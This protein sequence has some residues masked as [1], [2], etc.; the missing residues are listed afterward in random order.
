[1]TEEAIEVTTSISID[2]VREMLI[3]GFES[4][5]YSSFVIDGYDTNDKEVALDP[6]T[7]WPHKDYPG[8]AYWATVEGCAVIVQDEYEL[9]EYEYEVTLPGHDDA[10][11]PPK[12]RLDLA[13]IKKG[14]Q[15][16]ATKY[17]DQFNDIVSENDDT[18]TGDVFIQ[19]CLLGE[20]VYG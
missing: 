1:M 5:S 16:M 17:P 13:A 6:E 15:V 7:G 11:E 8:Y 2:R 19:C 12:L 10:A 9:E 20:A 3:T 18:I 14:L 4:G